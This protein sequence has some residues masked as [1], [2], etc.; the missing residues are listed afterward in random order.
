MIMIDH[1]SEKDEINE[2]HVKTYKTI[3]IITTIIVT[4]LAIVFSSQGVPFSEFTPSDIVGLLIKLALA[5]LFIERAVEVAMI[6]W[7][8]KGKQK[9][10]SKVLAEK[11]KSGLKADDQAGIVTEGQI[12]ASEGLE[13]H[14]AE[15]K[16]LAIL[17]AFGMGV[18]IS[19]L[20]LRALQPLLDADVFLGIG[21]VQRALF[22]GV[23]TLI[24]GA[25]LGSGSEGI[26]KILDT[27]LSWVDK[28]RTRIKNEIS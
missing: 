1:K 23:D 25:L 21:K 11:R 19:A 18:I 8:G 20:G 24:T 27:F 12:S 17:S 15:T 6:S 2:K 14:S 16:T 26:H 7:R 13:A 9:F 22:T 5:A 3:S 4:I 28:Y 10:V